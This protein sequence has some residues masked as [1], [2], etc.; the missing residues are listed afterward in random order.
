[1]AAAQSSVMEPNE[2]PIVPI[3][4]RHDV[5]WYYPA[6]GAGDGGGAHMTIVLAKRLRAFPNPDDLLSTAD[7]RAAADPLFRGTDML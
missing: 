2:G 1:M 5:Q 6:A 3:Q 4:H 7:A